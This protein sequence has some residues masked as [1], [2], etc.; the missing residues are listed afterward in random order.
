MKIWNESKI[1]QPYHRTEHTTE[2][3]QWAF[4]TATNPASEDSPSTKICIVIITNFKNDNERPKYIK[5]IIIK[6]HT[7]LKKD[8]RLLTWDSRNFAKMRRGLTCFFIP[9]LYI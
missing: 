1:Q 9:P 3:H 6:N 4:N 2:C 5:E 7:R 8:Q